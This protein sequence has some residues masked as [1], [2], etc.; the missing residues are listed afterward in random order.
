MQTHKVVETIAGALVLT[1][2]V[3]FAGFAYSRAGVGGGSG[4]A[5]NATFNSIDGLAVGNDVRIAGVKVGVVSALSLDRTSY[6]A[7]VVLSI[8]RDVAVPEDTAAKIASE[9]LLGGAYVAL[10]I[11]GSEEMLAPG[12]EIEETQGAVSLTDLI[13]QAIFSGG[14]ADR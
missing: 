9:S 7:V 1:V 2:A 10:S 4:Y 3:Y 6:D 14:G 11:V 13:G 8:D 12:D 5:L